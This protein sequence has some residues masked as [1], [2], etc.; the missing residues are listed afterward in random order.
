MS[1]AKKDTDVTTCF[2]LNIGAE[3]QQIANKK[4]R[5]SHQ[6]ICSC[7]SNQR[8]SKDVCQKTKDRH[9]NRRTSKNTEG[10]KSY[11]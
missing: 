11:T 2:Y 8:D 4:S 7:M 9:Q 6:R 3:C 5:K 10:R 1:I